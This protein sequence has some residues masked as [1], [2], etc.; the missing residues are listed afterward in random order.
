MLGLGRRQRLL[1]GPEGVTLRTSDGTVTTIRYAD[2][3]LLERPAEDEIVLWDRD[4]DRIYVPGVFWRAGRELIAEIAAAL[5]A[6]I[7][8]EDRISLDLID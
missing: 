7:V 4:G 6:D 5:P 8:I 2:C 1:I 3:V